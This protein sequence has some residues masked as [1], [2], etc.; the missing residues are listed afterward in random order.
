MDLFLPVYCIT[1][2]DYYSST[3]FFAARAR[4]CAERTR[5]FW[6]INS[7][8]GAL[9]APPVHRKFAASYSS[10]IKITYF[11]KQNA[12]IQAQTR[13]ARDV[14]LSTGLSCTLLSCIAPY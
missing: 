9:R 12:S 11:P 7:P 3:I 2:K 13:A 8:K 4:P 1:D 5:L 10:K 6:L 14:Y